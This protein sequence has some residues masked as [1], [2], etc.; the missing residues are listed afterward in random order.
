MPL[1]LV[2]WQVNPAGCDFGPQSPELQTVG[3]SLLHA[4][5]FVKSR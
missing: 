3:D 5:I 2:S 1:Y 4:M